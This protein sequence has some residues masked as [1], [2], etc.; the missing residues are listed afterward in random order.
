MK[1]DVKLTGD[2]KN[3]D[4]KNHLQFPRFNIKLY[5]EDT[6]I[7]LERLFERDPV[8]AK[9]TNEVVNENSDLFLAEII[10]SLEVSL[11]EKF[12]NIANIITKSFTYEEL[13]P[14]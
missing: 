4:G 1:A 7:N 6:H 5:I 8:I 10:P 2:L 13:F 12:T 3:I 11:A 14:V 9:A